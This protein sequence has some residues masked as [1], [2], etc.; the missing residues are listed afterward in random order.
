MERLYYNHELGL[1]EL[2]GRVLHCGDAIE[3]RVFGHRLPG[4]IAYDN[5]GWYFLT[6]DQVGIRLHTGLSACYSS[7]LPS[8]TILEC[9]NPQGSF[10]DAQGQSA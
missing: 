7:T 2:D 4:N 8:L 6:L 5:S 9:T 10:S 1:V 3:I